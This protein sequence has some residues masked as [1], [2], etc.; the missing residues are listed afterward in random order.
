MNPV[1][2][3]A[4]DHAGFEVKQKL[5]SF[6][7][8]VLG[9]E[10]VD[11]GAYTLNTEDDFTDFIVKAA[12]NVSINPSAKAIILGGSGQGEAILANRFHGVRAAV[13]YGGNTEILTLSREHNDAN[14]LSLGARFVSYEEAQKAVML[15]LNTPHVPV[16]K[17]DRRI[18]ATDTLSAVQA[19]PISHHVKKKKTDDSVNKYSLVP[20]VPAQSFSVIEN[21]CTLLDGIAG[22]IQIDIVDGVFAHP[23][24]WPFTTSIEEL[25]LLKIY[26]S[27]FIVEIDCLCMEPLQYLDKCAALG[28]RRVIVHHKSTENYVKCVEHARLH[29]YRIGLGILPTTA[30]SEIEDIV[31]MFDFIQVMGIKH[32]GS[33]GQPFEPQALATVAEINKKFP[34]LEI[35]VDGGVNEETLRALRDA[36]TTRF[37]VG[38]AITNAVDAVAVYKQLWSHLSE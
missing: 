5:F 37:A 32:I 22:E 2:Y 3:F 17:Y 12:R 14:I 16:L 18:V 13:F 31:T 26:S 27:K 30:V 4:T 28:A 36:G 7:R 9:Y 25:K 1:I 20:A 24:S 21:L 38:S 6:V 8:D 19:V 10:V 23:P 33:Q 11:C 34:V 35:A 29:K 15:W